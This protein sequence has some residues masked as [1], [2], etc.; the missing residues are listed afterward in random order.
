MAYNDG[1]F[2]KAFTIHEIKE[3]IDEIGWFE[4]ILTYIGLIIIV[5]VI[6]VVVTALIGIIFTLFGI[7]GA[8]LGADPSG[9]F[10]L[11]AFVNTAISMFIVG[12]Y[13]SIFA[14]RSMGLL[15]TMQI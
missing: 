6:S 9:V 7:S 1:A 11:G 10:V 8:V 4:C 13:L 2:S 15:Y 12:P 14:S 5:I 3:V